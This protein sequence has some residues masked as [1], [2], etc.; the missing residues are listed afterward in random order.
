MLREKNLIAA[1]TE[2]LGFYL[3]GRVEAAV[4]FCRRR[5]AGDVGAEAVEFV[6]VR[7]N[8]VSLEVAVQIGAQRDP[9]AF[10]RLIRERQGQRILLAS[11][12][13]PQ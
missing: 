12:Q 10:L 3:R 2:S 8:E 7:V 1:D 4:L 6:S 5:D 13:N 11:V 9:H